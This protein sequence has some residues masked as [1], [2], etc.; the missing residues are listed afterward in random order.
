VARNCTVSGDN[1]R[2]ITA[3]AGT[4]VPFAVTCAAAGSVR[5]TTATSG[6]DVTLNGYGVCIDGSGNPCFR[7]DWVPAN[8]AVTLDAV[9]AG[10]HT[11]TLTGLAE[12]CRVSGGAA[13]AVTVPLDGTVDV[14]FDVGC[15]LAERIAF[16]SGGA[17]AVI[18]TDGSA[19]Q[20]ITPGSAPAWSRDGARLAYD[21]A[22]DICVI[23]ADG[24][25]LARLTFDGGNHQPS[26]SPDGLKIAFA[27]TRGG[28]S[29]LYV[30][31]ASG[32]G[33]LRWTQG[34]GF[35]GSPAWSPDGTK[36]AFDCRV[37]AGNDDICVVNADGTG[38]ARLTINPARDYGAAWKPDGSTLAFATTRYGADEIALMS[39]TGGS[40]TRIGIG[41]PGFAPT[42][43]VDGSQL[44]FVQK[45]ECYDGC[46][47]YDVILVATSD[48][49][50]V[51]ALGPGDEPAW[52]PHP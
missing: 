39:L 51:R 37:D 2:T 45:Y 5:V 31:A 26:W 34:V 21:C 11:V 49:A 23:N 43:S 18:R 7:S 40:V 36:I 9:I 22:Q 27:R 46:S 41:L 48:G 20:S 1:P 13:R 4:E 14:A 32:S 42:W 38:F 28:V 19:F 35:V 3:T 50:A 16:S 8:D 6:I 24:S 25:G 10:P 47:T 30:M 15:I 44:A 33:A 17:I 12:N 29:D 52:K